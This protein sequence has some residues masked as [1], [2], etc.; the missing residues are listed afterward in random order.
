MSLSTWHIITTLDQIISPLLFSECD[1]YSYCFSKQLT[2]FQGRSSFS[3]NF[4]LMDGAFVFRPFVKQVKSL[5]LL[6]GTLS[7]F[8]SF[9]SELGHKFSHELTAPHLINKDQVLITCL[10]RGHLKQEL[11][12]TYKI[13]E[14]LAYLDQIAK[15]VLDLTN[16]VQA[17]GGTLVFVPSYTFLDNL[18]KRL[19]LLK[20]ENLFIEPKA[21]GSGEFESVLKKYHNRISLKNP[22]V[23]I[24]VYRGKASEGVDFKDSSARAVICVGIPYPSF[25]DPQIE[26]KKEYNDKHKHF[27]GRRWYETQAFRAV[28]QAAGRAIR[29]KDDWGIIVML[30]SR[31]QDKRISNQLSGWVNQYLQV[32]DDYEACLK[33]VIVFLDNKNK[34]IK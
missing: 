16:K 32:H 9:S 13:A 4:W 26:L 27:N 21:G 15:I 22:V 24:W 34:Q 28:N 29:H 14:S 12:G 25:V 2:D 20:S 10:K 5:I 7:P 33:S 17:H 1:V 11:V 23:L 31:Y 18:H 6:S 30:D 3:Y 19:K 8:V